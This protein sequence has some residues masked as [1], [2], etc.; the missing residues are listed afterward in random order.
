M[1]NTQAL[2]E[3]VLKWRAEKLPSK[4]ILYDYKP[5]CRNLMFEDEEIVRET[6]GLLKRNIELWARRF[7]ESYSKE[8]EFVSKS[9]LSDK[10]R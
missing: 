10:D 3:F 5:F 4:D 1:R 7:S 6:T 8:S 9:D 2:K